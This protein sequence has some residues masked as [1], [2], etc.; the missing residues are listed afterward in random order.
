LY[1]LRDIYLNETIGE[2]KDEGLK[3]QTFHKAGYSIAER[4]E[5]FTLKIHRNPKSDADGFAKQ[6]KEKMQEDQDEEYGE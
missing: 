3:W 2:F 5:R 6:I 1:E 4:G